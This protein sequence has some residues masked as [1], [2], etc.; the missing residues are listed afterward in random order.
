MA[1]QLEALWTD[2]AKRGELAG[3]LDRRLESLT[4][5]AIRPFPGCDLC[6][7]ACRYR[8][9]IE[10]WVSDPDR[11]RAFEG[12]LHQA[13]MA[14]HDP[15]WRQLARQAL[16]AVASLLD[17]AVPL[18]HRH[19]AALCYA[20]Q[21]LAQRGWEAW[22]ASQAAAHIFAALNQWGEDHAQPDTSAL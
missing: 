5:V 15:A 1:A 17:P 21:L 8:A 16:T 22:L 12:T 13:S 2:E 14:R 20:L 7:S 18:V 4:A 3:H 6:P 11:A 19:G 10:P 9:F